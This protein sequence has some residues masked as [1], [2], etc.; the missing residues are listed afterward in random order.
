MQ[1]LH[2]NVRHSQKQV[3]NLHKLRD[4]LIRLNKK[5]NKFST[6]RYSIIQIIF[7]NAINSGL[8]S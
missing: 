3:T 6:N 4:I 5:I 2:N 1:F 7:F 8:L